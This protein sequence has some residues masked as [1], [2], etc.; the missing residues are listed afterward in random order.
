MV[1]HAALVT[2]RFQLTLDNFPP[3]VLDVFVHRLSCD[4]SAN[5]RARSA[6]VLG[7][8]ADCRARDTLANLLEDREWFVRLQAVKSA[9]RRG[10]QGLELRVAQCLSDP[11]WRVREAAAHT[12]GQQPRSGADVLLHQFRETED[13]YMKEQ[14]A[15]ELER[16]GLIGGW[17]SHL[18]ETGFERETQ[19]LFQLVEMGK[20]GL[21]QDLLERT[22][23]DRQKANLSASLELDLPEQEQSQ[24]RQ[25]ASHSEP[26]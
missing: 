18:G 24:E 2:G 23:S 15:E 4:P 25:T 19:A 13:V 20:T 5:V 7:Y 8:F 10:P 26:R 1:K 22:I 3:Q 11:D 9:G 12:F 16:S 17:L 21:L 14:I 6:I